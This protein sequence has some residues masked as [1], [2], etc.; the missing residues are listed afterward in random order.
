MKESKERILSCLH[1]IELDMSIKKIYN[2]SIY[3][4][5]ELHYLLWAPYFVLIGS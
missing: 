5:Y 4:K 3:Q 2:P 1:A